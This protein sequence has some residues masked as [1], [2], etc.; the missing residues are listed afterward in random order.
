MK[1]DNLKVSDCNVGRG[2]FARRAFTPGEL[3]IVF[4]GPRFDRNHGIHDTESGANLL[5][6]G[7][8]TY[9]LPEP[10][11]LFA[12]HSCN[13]NAGLI[14]GRRMVAIRP[15]AENEEI[16]FDYSTTMAENF[17]TMDCRCGDPACRKVVTDFKYLPPEVQSR[18]LK[19]GIV[20]RFIASRFHICATGL[21]QPSHRSPSAPSD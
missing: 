10:P 11:A 5:Q 2:L 17:W 8:R 1:P 9:I 7:W 16:R 18:Y 4:G 19:L 20:P 6:T 13:P 21:L 15:I 12:N 14:N 3:I